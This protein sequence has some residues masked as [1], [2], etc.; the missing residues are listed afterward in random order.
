MKKMLCFEMYGRVEVPADFPV[1]L[2]Y[3]I[4][5]RKVGEIVSQMEASDLPELGSI[6]RLS[7][8]CALRALIKHGSMIEA[9]KLLRQYV[10]LDEDGNLRLGLREAK[11][12]C[13]GLKAEMNA[14]RPPKW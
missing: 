3:D 1:G 11:D 7:F 9:I 13:D 12:I 6:S 4:H 14:A 10:G 8:E 5:G 2:L